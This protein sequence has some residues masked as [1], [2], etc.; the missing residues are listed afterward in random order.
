MVGYNAQVAVDAEHH[1]IVA[2]EVTNSGSNRALLSPMAKAPRDAMGKTR[3]RAVAD[4]GYYMG[5]RSRSARMPGLRYPC[6]QCCASPLEP[7]LLKERKQVL[8]D[9]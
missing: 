7:P 1:L 3:L 9:G 6:S 5:L 2:R 8:H 4:R